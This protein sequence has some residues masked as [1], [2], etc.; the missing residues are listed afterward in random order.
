MANVDSSQQPAT[1]LVMLY[2][3]ADDIPVKD[4]CWDEFGKV[5]DPSILGEECVKMLDRLEML[6]LAGNVTLVALYD[7][8]AKLQNPKERYKPSVQVR[9]QDNKQWQLMSDSIHDEEKIFYI[10]KD[11]QRE[12]NTGHYLTL[13]KFIR[14]AVRHFPADNT[15]LAIIAHGGGWAPTLPFLNPDGTPISPDHKSQPDD[16][17]WQKKGPSSSPGLNGMCIDYTTCT[18][19]ST[20][21][22]RLAFEHGLAERRHLGMKDKLDVVFLDACLMSMVEVAYEVRECVDYLVAGENLLAAALP[23][24]DYLHKENLSGDTK[25]DQ[26]AISIVRLYNEKCKQE[27]WTIGALSTKALDQLRNHICEL[28]H[29]L[30]CAIDLSITQ[31]SNVLYNKDTVLSRI[32]NAYGPSQKFDYDADAEI[33]GV[34]EGYVDLFALAYYLLRVLENYPS[35]WSEQIKLHAD[36]ARKQAVAIL[37]MLAKNRENEVKMRWPSKLEQYLKGCISTDPIVIASKTS[38]VASHDIPLAHA[39]GLSIYFPLGEKEDRNTI[40]NPKIKKLL[41]GHPH[42]YFYTRQLLFTAKTDDHPSGHLWANLL[43]KLTEYLVD[44]A[45]DWRNDPEHYYRTP[46]QLIAR[47]KN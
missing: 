2:M 17:N 36:K 35:D 12:L 15:M 31:E 5:E 19:I 16:T 13:G 7:D 28:A 44:D 11:G 45:D 32:R 37:C 10:R 33:D 8:S 26:L 3:A 21:Q 22:L 40:N 25:P 6:D 14:W 18:A 27:P 41:G 43:N 23:Y 30:I 46:R 39:E 24:E 9:T 34:R 1:W 4:I 20:E 38:K 42:L 47:P 29:E